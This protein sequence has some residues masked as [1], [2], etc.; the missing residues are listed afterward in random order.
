[1]SDDKR[2]WGFH[3]G[4]IRSTPEVPAVILTFKSVSSAGGNIPIG[5]FLDDIKVDVVY[6]C[7]D[8][9][10]D[11]KPDYVGTDSDNN[12][13]SDALEGLGNITFS[14]LTAYTGGSIKGRYENLGVISDAQRSPIVTGAS[15]EQTSA[16]AIIDTADNN[17]CS[18]DLSST[19]TIDKAISKIG[20]KVAFTLFLKNDG[21]L[22]ATNVMTKDKLPHGFITHNETHSTRPSST[23]IQKA[24]EFGILAPELWQVVVA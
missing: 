14:Q 10:A 5:R 17:T 21:G 4:S 22:D 9:N 2:A 18:V 13:C 12:G 3:C 24:Q 19:K 16:M 6:N 11:G 15:Y 23:P 20:D 1:M 7:I 8:S